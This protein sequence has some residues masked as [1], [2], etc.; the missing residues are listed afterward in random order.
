MIKW[1]SF[2]SIVFNYIESSH[3]RPEATFFILIIPVL[4]KQ[5]TSYAL[6]L[7]LEHVTKSIPDMFVGIATRASSY[8]A[9]SY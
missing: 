6:K 2:G 5:A 7:Q 3:F 4:D 8:G 9:P 1:R